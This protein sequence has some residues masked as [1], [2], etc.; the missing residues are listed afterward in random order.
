MLPKFLEMPRM[1]QTGPDR[2]DAGF[3]RPSTIFE[4][5]RQGIVVDAADNMLGRSR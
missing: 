5:L 1:A 2:A 4:I 3:T